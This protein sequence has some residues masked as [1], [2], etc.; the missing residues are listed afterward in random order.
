MI[1]SR[2]KVKLV[3]DDLRERGVSDEALDAVHAPIGLPIG[4]ILVEEIALSIAAQL[5]A[6]RRATRAAPVRGPEPVTLSGSA[7]A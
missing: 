7:G 3:F 4:S 6:V 1:G 5:V 2:R